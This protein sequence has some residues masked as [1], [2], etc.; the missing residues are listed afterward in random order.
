MTKKNESLIAALE[1]IA[2]LKFKLMAA[3]AEIKAARQPV[4]GHFVLSSAERIF[5]ARELL[6]EGRE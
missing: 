2:E 3:Q 1:E 6:E 4:F 5:I